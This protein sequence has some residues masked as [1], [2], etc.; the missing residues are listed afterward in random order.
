MRLE[1]LRKL[2][3]NI[4]RW[5]LMIEN[6]TDK[7]KL[8]CRA[9]ILHWW[10][11][12]V[13]FLYIYICKTFDILFQFLPFPSLIFHT[14]TYTHFP[15]VLLSFMPFQFTSNPFWPTAGY[16][17]REIKPPWISSS[18][19]RIWLFTFNTNDILDHWRILCRVC[20]L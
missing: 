19:S 18:I 2:F 14:Q 7:L 3:K 8:F 10:L 20:A 12:K 16:K 1:S 6:H 4:H 11:L 17:Q 13:P 15:P 9:K 5:C